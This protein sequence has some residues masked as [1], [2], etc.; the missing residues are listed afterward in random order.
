MLSVKGPLVM[1]PVQ[2][3]EIFVGE[4]LIKL[5]LMPRTFEMSMKNVAVRQVLEQSPDRH[6]AQKKC[7]R[8]ERPPG[9]KSDDEHSNR[10]QRVHRGHR[11]ERMARNCGLLAL[12]NAEWL[13]DRFGLAEIVHLINQNPGR[14]TSTLADAEIVYY[15]PTAVNLK[16]TPLRIP[17]RHA[18]R[19]L[20]YS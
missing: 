3:V 12:V 19:L 20:R 6:S 18:L 5:V 15:R 16:Q 8:R 4:R 13:L 1:L 14:K 10:V 2:R 11:I 17:D 7:E 9:A